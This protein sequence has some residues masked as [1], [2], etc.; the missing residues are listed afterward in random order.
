MLP[1]VK[2]AEMLIAKDPKAIKEYLPIDGLPQLKKLASELVFTLVERFD[3]EPYSDV[4][5]K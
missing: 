5:A 4:P 3:I 2:E 1:S